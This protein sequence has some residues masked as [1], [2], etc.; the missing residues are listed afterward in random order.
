MPTDR[1]IETTPTP[2]GYGEPAYTIRVELLDY[3]GRQQ[4]VEFDSYGVLRELLDDLQAHP[5]V[6]A[7]LAESDPDAE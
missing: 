4:V 1:T 6:Q 5:E 7:W 3:A 2:V